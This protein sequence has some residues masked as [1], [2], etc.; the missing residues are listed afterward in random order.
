[1]YSDPFD[2]SKSELIV[3]QLLDPGTQRD[4]RIIAKVVIAQVWRSGIFQGPQLTSITY[5]LLQLM[6]KKVS[7]QVWTFGKSKICSNR[8]FEGPKM[9]FKW[10]VLTISIQC[11]GQNS[12]KV[13]NRHLQLI[14][15]CKTPRIITK[16]VIIQIWI[17]KGP[18]L[19]STIYWLVK[20]I[21]KKVHG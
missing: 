19:T 14:E 21:P 16:I 11:F 20:L 10:S 5:Q 15:T 6:H 3:Y 12:W 7:E 18:K 13:Q 2:T 17:L 4:P 9:V 1:M 8:S